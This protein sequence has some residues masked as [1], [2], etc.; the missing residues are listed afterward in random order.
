MSDKK[1]NK[2]IA[3]L[4]RS[5]NGNLHSTMTSEVF[6]SLQQ[7]DKGGL[8]VIKYVPEASRKTEKSPV[9]YLE[10]AEPRQSA[11]SY[12]PA[13]KAAPADDV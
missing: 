9:A 1:F 2:S 3:P 8:L 7:L 13:P 12:R 6:D 5:A 11:S 10:Y 4:F